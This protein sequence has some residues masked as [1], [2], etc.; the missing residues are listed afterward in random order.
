MNI[1][2]KI[3][4]LIEKLLIIESKWLDAPLKVSSG[5]LLLRET[6]SI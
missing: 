3:Q 2:N 4:K 6:E 5:L 1:K